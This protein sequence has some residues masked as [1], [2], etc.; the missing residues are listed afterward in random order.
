M[1][2]TLA[3]HITPIPMQVVFAVIVVPSPIV[4]TKAMFHHPIQITPTIS[5]TPTLAVSAA[6]VIPSPNAITLVTYHP[7]VPLT[8]TPVAFA[9]QAAPSSTAT[10]LV[11]YLPTPIPVVFAEQGNLTVSKTAIMSVLFYQEQRAESLAET[12]TSPIPTIWRLAVIARPREVSLKQM[13]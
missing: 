3:T 2:F 11:T 12:A 1:Y 9:E 8:V 13:R 10:M 4:T 5:L 7:L 6:V